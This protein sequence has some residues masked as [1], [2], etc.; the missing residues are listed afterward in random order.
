M[1]RAAT[2]D[3]D[4]ATAAVREASGVALKTTGLIS[5]IMETVTHVGWKTNN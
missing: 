5:P 1:H 2:G 4:G 3:P